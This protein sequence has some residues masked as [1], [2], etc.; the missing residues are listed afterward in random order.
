MG[1]SADNINKPAGFCVACK[2][3]LMAPWSPFH[4]CHKIAEIKHFKDERLSPGV[5]SF[6]SC[7]TFPSVQSCDKTIC[8]DGGKLT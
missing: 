2:L 5:L 1:Q 6:S 8:H 3:D 4:Y 7:P